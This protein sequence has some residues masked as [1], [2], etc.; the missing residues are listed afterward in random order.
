MAAELGSPTNMEDVSRLG[1][2]WGVVASFTILSTAIVGLRTY[3][4]KKIVKD[5][6][7][8]DGFVVAAMVGIPFQSVLSASP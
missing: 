8:D 7:K 4:R 2:I 1:T 6:G 3:A 5:F